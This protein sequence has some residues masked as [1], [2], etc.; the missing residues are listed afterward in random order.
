MS[1]RFCYS[2]LFKRNHLHGN[3]ITTRKH[4][5]FVHEGNYAAEVEIEIINS[6]DS[7]APYISLDEALKLDRV[8]LSVHSTLV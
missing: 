4:T 2:V 3:K 7:W 8:I 5:K 6:E 1:K